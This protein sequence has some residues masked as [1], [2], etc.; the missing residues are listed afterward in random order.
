MKQNNWLILECL[1]RQNYNSWI[2]INDFRI[3]FCCTKV[4]C[5]IGDLIEK[6]KPVGTE[7]YDF[8]YQ[9]NQQKQ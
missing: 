7:K 4:N 5:S 3:D 1:E 8:L 2:S 6:I 9:I